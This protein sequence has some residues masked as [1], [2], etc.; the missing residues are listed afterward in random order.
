[1]SDT[2]TVAKLPPC[3]VCTDGTP[4]DY[5]AKTNLG[6]WANLCDRHWRRLTGQ[7]LG[8]GYGQRLVLRASE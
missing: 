7:R 1:M 3:D 2:V 4:A 6:P 5:D 8:T